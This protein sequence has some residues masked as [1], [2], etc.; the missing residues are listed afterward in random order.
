MIK[1]GLIF[2][3]TAFIL[4]LA[5]SLVSPLCA[6]CAGLVMG[7]AAGYV[8]GGFDK[9]TAPRE[10][11][12]IGGIAGAITG[13]I[14]FVGGLIGGILN[15]TTLTPAAIE[16]VYKNFGI[17]NISINQSQIL[18]YQILGAICIGVFN[19]LWMAILGIVGGALW[20][21]LRGKNQPVTILPPQEP[22]PPSI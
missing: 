11:V 6:P 21:Q 14:A 7:L 4:V 15:S 22:L 16:S 18:L 3:V 1:S 17:T 5:S 12:R 19:I 9:P 10:G 8:A 20:Y 2:G 13:C